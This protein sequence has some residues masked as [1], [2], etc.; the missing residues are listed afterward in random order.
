LRRTLALFFAAVAVLVLSQASH[1]AGQTVRRNVVV[2]M[3]DDFDAA[4]IDT[5]VARGLAPNI[6]RYFV[7]EGVSFTNSFATSTF[8]SPNRATFLTGQ[9]PHNHGEI[10]GDAI[11][12]SV[13]KLNEANTVAT[14]LKGAGY[15][16]THV[17]RYLTGYGWFTPSTSKP[18]GWDGWY[19][20]VDPTT[21]STEQY[22]INANGT[23]VDFGAVAASSGVELHQTDVLAYLAGAAIQQAPSFS[24]PFFV[25]ISPITFNRERYPG[26]TTYNVCPD[27][28]DP[29]FGGTY[30]GVAQKPPARHRD[31]V[32]GDTAQF[33][34]P[35]PPSFNEE[36]I[37]DKPLWA[38]VNPRLTDFEI[39]CLQKRYWRKL[40][41]LRGIDDLV[42]YVMGSLNAIKALDN[43]VVIL[44]SDAGDMDGQHRFPE[45]MPAYESSIRV[46]LFIR[47]PASTT[48]KTVAKLVLNTDLAPTIAAY[49]N[50][51]PALTVDGRSLVPLIANPGLSP[52]RSMGLVEHVVE[53]QASTTF[54][55]PPNY[56]A[57]RTVAPVARTFV[58]Y[59]TITTSL[60]GELYD[61]DA[62]PDQLDNRFLDPARQTE[63]G[64]FDIFLYYFKSCKGSTCALLENASF[65]N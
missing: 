28:S 20:L 63:V 46:P 65:L 60:N 51:T 64:R 12:G 48:P 44:T 9:Y 14:W 35:Q 39:D 45:K 50:V 42:G 43:T 8:G 3:L 36:D 32:F 16:T 54:G 40:E 5:A 26:P 6:K 30:W 53:T 2:I 47:A 22:V 55:Y 24:R 25:S 19:G 59:P 34:L 56:L 21:W 41:N 17:G 13:P 11:F 62:D 33:P 23:L 15:R 27:A 52:W 58:R 31:T 1:V 18:P 29:I 38:Q 57:I 10:G 4:T 7:D 61:L 49:A 37:S